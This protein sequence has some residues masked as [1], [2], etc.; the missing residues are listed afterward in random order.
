MSDAPSVLG[1]IFGSLYITAEVVCLVLLSVSLVLVVIQRRELDR[2]TAA[3][4]RSRLPSPEERKHRQSAFKNRV[5]ALVLTGIVTFLKLLTSIVQIV[6]SSTKGAAK[7]WASA[8]YFPITVL[9]VLMTLVVMAFIALRLLEAS[10]ACG[11]VPQTEMKVW[12][13]LMPLVPASHLLAVVLITFTN[14]GRATNAYGGSMDWSIVG[15]LTSYPGVI[16]YVV[17]MILCTAFVVYAGIRIRGT[18]AKSSDTATSKQGSGSNK[19]RRHVHI[20][21]AISVVASAL[22]TLS[23]PSIVFAFIFA[24]PRAFGYLSLVDFVVAHGATVMFTLN[25]VYVYTPISHHTE[26]AVRYARTIQQKQK[27][28]AGGKKEGVEENNEMDELG[29]PDSKLPSQIMAADQTV[30]SVEEEANQ[31]T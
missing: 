17:N 3:D 30:D 2:S 13:V 15:P 21:V 10:T 11:D 12:R 28:I 25:I 27:R 4:N 5:A 9:S 19:S 22:A 31:E 20:F 24:P 1:I 16:Q 14:I 29:S 23:T 26:K 18:L 6:L 7:A 8:V